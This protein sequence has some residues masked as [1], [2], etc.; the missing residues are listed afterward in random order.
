M[1]ELDEKMS[2]GCVVTTAQPMNKFLSCK[3]NIHYKDDD[4]NESLY[5]S[6]EDKIGKHYANR[7]NTNIIIGH[8]Y[9]NKKVMSIWIT[10][11]FDEEDD[12]GSLTESFMDD[13]EQSY[14]KF[15]KETESENMEIAVGF[16]PSLFRNRYRK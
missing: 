4:I 16:T 7:K 3:S 11:N 8:P 5:G 2:E 14:E 1:L 15:K 12:C 6:L 13:F 9:N 10:L